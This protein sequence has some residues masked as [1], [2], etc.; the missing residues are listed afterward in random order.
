MLCCPC[1]S[2]CFPPLAHAWTRSSDT[3]PATRPTAYTSEAKLKAQKAK[4]P[5]GGAASLKKSLGCRLHTWR[6]SLLQHFSLLFLR[7]VPIVALRTVGDFFRLLARKLAL[8]ALAM[9]LTE[10]CRGAHDGWMRVEVADTESVK[11]GC[12][13]VSVEAEA[14]QGRWRD[15]IRVAV[16]EVGAHC[17]S[18]IM[19]RPVAESQPLDV[20]FCWRR[21]HLQAVGSSPYVFPTNGSLRRCCQPHAG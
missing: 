8:Q 1:S 10:R 4:K 16:E 7:K 18:Y 19:S 13:I 6:H 21:S 15:A 17:L 12:R 20:E 9:R 2:V 3:T 5:D 11:E 14:E